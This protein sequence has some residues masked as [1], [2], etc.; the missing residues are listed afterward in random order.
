MTLQTERLILRPVAPDD[1]T[2]LHALLT[3]PGV[4]RVIFD[5]EI[6][7]PARTQEIIEQSAT[8]FAARQFGLWTARLRSD[9]SLVGFGGLWYFRDPPELEL[10]YGV[11]DAR[12]KQGFGREIARAIVAYGFDVL[13]LPEIRASTQPAHH[14]SRRVLEDLGFTFEREAIAGGLETVF[15]RK[16]AKT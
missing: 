11:G 15:Y 3:Q 14:R 7:P 8:L 16:S 12:V 10:L 5:D 6:I 9:G 13:E 1:Q 4:R 2:T